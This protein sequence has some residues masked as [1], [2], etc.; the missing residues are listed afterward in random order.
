[1][2]THMALRATLDSVAN[3]VAAVL[4]DG[5]KARFHELFGAQHTPPQGRH[6]H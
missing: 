6:L 5:Q 2:N 3:A 1:M 4:D